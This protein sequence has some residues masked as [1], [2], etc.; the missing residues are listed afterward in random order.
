MPTQ[1]RATT[2]T[3]RK[4]HY[5]SLCGGMVKVGE[6]YHVS[7]NVFDGRVYDWRTCLPCQTDGI[8]NEV[9]DWA[10]MPDE[11]VDSESAHDWAHEARHADPGHPKIVRMA[12]DFLRRQGCNCE[13]CEQLTRPGGDS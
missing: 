4:V 12:E 5:C 6:K 7:T 1:L 13:T 3:A 8:I 2:R 9:Y 11:G 10:G